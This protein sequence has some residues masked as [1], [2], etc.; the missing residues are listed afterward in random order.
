MPRK[1]ILKE[2]GLNGADAPSGFKFL[3]LDSGGDIGLKEGATF[4]PIGGGLEYITE[5]TTEGNKNLEISI[6]D[7][8]NTSE[9]KVNLTAPNGIVQ[10]FTVDETGFPLTGY[11]GQVI[12]FTQVS[13]D[14]NGTG[15]EFEVE[16]AGPGFIGTINFLNRGLNYE[17]GDIITTSDEGSGALTLTIDSIDDVDNYNRLYSTNGTNTGEIKV[18]K[19]SISQKVEQ[20]SNVSEIIVEQ[21]PNFGTQIVQAS[22]D[23][24]NEAYLLTNPTGIFYQLSDEI[25]NSQMSISVN[26]LSVNRT[27][28]TNNLQTQFRV[29]DEVY[30]GFGTGTSIK[31]EPTE[32]KQEFVGVNSD[33]S[34]N[35]SNYFLIREDLVELGYSEPD[36]NISSGVLV[37]SERVELYSNDGNDVEVNLSLGQDN[38]VKATLVVNDFNTSD[39]SQIEVES[40]QIT[41]DTI[42]LLLPNIPTYADN[43]TAVANNYPEGGV[44]KTSTG[45]LRI[46]V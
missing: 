32:I 1:I 26:G 11:V 31:V 27:D 44:Y 15:L 20:G 2:D 43:A 36:T 18:E 21:N 13:T 45:E 19:K 37:N 22:T 40:T 10:T 5:D 35:V 29:E 4:S 42:A 23:G 30:I 28:N 39:L 17:V 9:I 14:G 24:T 8:T 6:S 12:T 25:D 3:G 16:F 38:G 33:N 7:G 34:E 41:L 46:V